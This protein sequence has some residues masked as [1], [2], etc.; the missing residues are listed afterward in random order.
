MN[1]WEL[2]KKCAEL[3]KYNGHKNWET[4]EFLNYYGYN[5]YWEEQADKIYHDAKKTDYNSKCQNALYDIEEFIEEDTLD[6]IRGSGLET[7]FESILEKA[8]KT[9]DF[10][11]IAKELLSNKCRLD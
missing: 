11:S 2:K 7:V 8:L 3:E 9:I 6:M 5:E 4:W 10:R 1:D